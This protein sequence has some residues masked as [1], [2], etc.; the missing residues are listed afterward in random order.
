MDVT[1][2][3]KEQSS[4]ANAEECE[5]THFDAK[6]RVNFDE[7]KLHCE[8]TFTA[9]IRKPTNRLVLDT[10]HLEITGCDHEYE[11]EAEIEPFGRPLA[12]K[13][14]EEE[15]STVGNKVT[16][17]ISYNTTTESTS[18]QWL[19][20][21]Q[22]ATKKAPFL[23]SQN[24]AIHCRAMMP[25]QDTPSVR[26]T[27]T[28]EITVP[29][30]LT[31]LASGVPS[32]EPTTSEDGT[33]RTFYW[34]QP[35][36]IASNIFGI[37]AGLLENRKLSHRCSVWAEPAVIDAAAWEFE[38]TEKQLQAYESVCGPYLWSNYY[39]I[40]VMPP[41]FP[42]GG[43]EQPCLTLA[44]PTLL[45]GDRSLVDVIVHEI[46]HVSRVLI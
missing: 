24:Q 29:A 9:V 11:V 22:T 15:G 13:L 5:T 39:S 2:L 25:C 6:F 44:T 31:G 36:P 27:F 3:T 38:G 1:K 17:T 16:V 46:A 32:G 7:K 45:C 35:V 8:V 20:P 37:A 12:I 43:M 4:V 26:T 21:E 41:S 10:S 18:L 33:T 30:E 34:K 28:C 19:D 14:S 42:Y 40:L 23:F